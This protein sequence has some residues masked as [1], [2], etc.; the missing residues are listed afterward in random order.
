MAPSVAAALSL[1]AAVTVGQQHDHH[2]K[3]KCISSVR[4]G[5]VGVYRCKVYP[6]ST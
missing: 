4:G 3:E 2:L 6:N 5:C 1:A